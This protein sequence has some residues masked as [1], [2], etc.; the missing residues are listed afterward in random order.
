MS[1]MLRRVVGMMKRGSSGLTYATWNPSDKGA[2]VTLSGSNL[3][4]SISSGAS[5]RA[6]T[7]K[8][9]GKWYWEISL[10]GSQYWFGGVS[11]ASQSLDSWLTTPESAGVQSNNYYYNS[12]AQTAGGTSFGSSSV[13]GFALDKDANTLAVYVNNT[14][15]VTISNVPTGAVFPS[16]GHLSGTG[17]YTANFGAS[18]FVYTPP[19]GYNAGVY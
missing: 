11:T 19:S 7:S 13:L 6:N 17:T 1:E 16:A 4:A 12:V 9:S 8:T 15:S 10:A 2:G 5:V 14:L 3:I 18:A